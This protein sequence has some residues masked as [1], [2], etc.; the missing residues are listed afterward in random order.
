MCPPYSYRLR[1]QDRH[2][3]NDERHAGDDPI[4]TYTGQ[5]QANLST[6]YLSISVSTVLY[7]QLEIS[8]GTTSGSTT[9]T[10]SAAILQKQVPRDHAGQLLPAQRQLLL[11]GDDGVILVM[12]AGPAA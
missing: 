1:P 6:R 2:A 8:A 5:S 10:V 4:L 11:A 3:E 7:K 9:P 12:V